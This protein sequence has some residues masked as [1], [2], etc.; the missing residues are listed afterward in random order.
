MQLH[1]RILIL[2]IVVSLSCLLGCSQEKASRPANSN[3][4]VYVDSLNVD[5]DFFEVS[6]PR[7]YSIKKN[8]TWLDEVTSY[9]F[10]DSLQRPFMNLNHGLHSDISGSQWGKFKDSL[11]AFIFDRKWDYNFFDEDSLKRKRFYLFDIILSSQCS[12]A[13]CPPSFVWFTYNPANVNQQVC[14]KIIFS[15]RYRKK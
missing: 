6:F 9:T 2:G 14:E 4:Q 3:L 15:L 5:G 12:K 13:F 8:G 7:S 1:M 11:D 10:Y